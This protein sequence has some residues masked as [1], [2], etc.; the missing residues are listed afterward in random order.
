MEEFSRNRG[1]RTAFSSFQL[2]AV[3]GCKRNSFSNRGGASVTAVAY[4]R[5]Y[6]SEYWGSSTFL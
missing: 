2:E 4:M 5:R 6:V 3:Q 1:E